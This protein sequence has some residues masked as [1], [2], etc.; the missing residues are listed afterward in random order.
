[1]MQNP[2]IVPDKFRKAYW[3]NIKTF[4]LLVGANLIAGAA[5][6]MTVTR[7][8]IKFLILPTYV[9]LPL[10]LA[11]M[12]VPPLLCYGKLTELYEKGNDMVE[13]QFIKIQKFRRTGNIE[14]YF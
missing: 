3:K 6:N 13:E 1:M 7:V 5:I 8:F 10:R 9:R 14:E 11:I 4:G 2:E 12:A